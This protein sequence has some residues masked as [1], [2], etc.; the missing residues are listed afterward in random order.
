MPRF[1]VEVRGLCSHKRHS[2]GPNKC[3][4]CDLSMVER[5]LAQGKKLT[6]PYYFVLL[7]LR[8]CGRK[9]DDKTEIQE[10]FLDYSIDIARKAIKLDKTDGCS[11]Y[12]GTLVPNTLVHRPTT[13]AATWL[14]LLPTPL[15]PPGSAAASTT[16]G[17]NCLICPC[18]HPG[19]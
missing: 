6:L 7:C 9:A 4:L 12:K 1:T 8:G 19:T 13:Q 5:M 16:C 18:C 17:P 2:R 14:C 15:P 10:F 11:R 3:L